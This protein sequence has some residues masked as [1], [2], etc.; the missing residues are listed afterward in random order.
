VHTFTGGILVQTVVTEQRIA[1]LE[2]RAYWLGLACLV[3]FAVVVVIWFSTTHRDSQVL[4][5]SAPQ[6]LR[7]R[8]L[9]VEDAMGR[10]R[11]LL[12]APFPS[13]RERSRQDARTTSIL[14]LDEEGHDRLTLGEELEPQIGGR[15]PVG[16]HR[17]ASGFGLVIHDGT[18]DERGA[19]SWLSNGRALITLDR[20]GTE[21]F[22]AMVND[23]TGETKIS[24][25]F[26]PEV[27]HDNSA[28][29]IGTK[30]S[31][32]FLRFNSKSGKSLAVFSTEDGRTPSFKT[33]DLQGSQPVEHLAN[34]P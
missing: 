7:V 24:L 12:G 8:G 31:S 1:R 11:I 27:A 18:G 28:I 19:Y 2:R 14:F 16:V 30:G 21:A 15:V 4:A 5:Q 33:F 23:K 32:S 29:E 26:P 9:I 22:A 17:I 10:P 34:T 6:I 3:Q 20:P 25:G 13:V